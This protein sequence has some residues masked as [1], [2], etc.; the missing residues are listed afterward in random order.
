MKVSLPTHVPMQYA[1]AFALILLALEIAEGTPVPLAL[2]AQAFV[3]VSAVA[4]NVAGG[5]VYPSGAFIFFNATLSLIVG[6]VTK[7]FLGEPLQSN[8]YAPQKTL[9]VYLVGMCFILIAAY[10]CRHLRPKKAL[11]E[12]VKVGDRVDKIGAGCFLLAVFT[13]YLLPAQ[14][15]GTFGQF[16]TAF[17]YLSIMI[18][19]YQRTRETDG[20]RSFHVMAFIAW[21]YLTLFLRRLRVLEAG[22]VCPK[23]GVGGNR[24]G[25]GLQNLRL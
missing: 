15:Q 22:P 25:S 14:V 6:L 18:P 4:F 16:N 20:R 10:L 12:D 21:V 17:I 9:L 1:Y 5:L 8:L 19:V 13:P 23:P 2:T 3:V 7:A 11:L 24:S